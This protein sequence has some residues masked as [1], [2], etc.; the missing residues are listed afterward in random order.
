[1]HFGSMFIPLSGKRS[2]RI[3][4]IGRRNLTDEQR[5]VL[6]GKMYEARKKHVGEHAGNQHTRKVE[7]YQNG[8]L[9]NE[10]SRTA[11]KIADELNIGYGTVVRAEKFSKDI[12]ALS[13]VST[14]FTINS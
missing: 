9:P 5:T 3:A 7:C 11:Q 14:P 4:E 10:P 2:P 6:I 12:V 13:E 8:N 1:M